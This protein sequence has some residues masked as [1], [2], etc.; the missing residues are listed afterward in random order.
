VHAVDVPERRREQVALGIAGAQRLDDPH[1]VLGGGVERFSSPTPSALTS[2]SLPPTTPTSQLEDDAEGG[3][4]IQQRRRSAQVLLQRQRRPVEHVRLEQRCPAAGDPGLGLLQ[5]RTEEA[6][7]AVGRA[8]VGMQ[9][10]QRRVLLGDDVREAGECAP[11][12]SSPLPDRYDAP[13]VV[14]W[15]M[16]SDPAS[17][18]PRRAALSVCEEVTL[19]AG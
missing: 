6:I 1:E 5:Q 8:V 19:T 15:T 9:G 2:S 13:P 3:A 7:G 16:P 11:P 14:T 10:D 18:K 12:A 4:A 17:A